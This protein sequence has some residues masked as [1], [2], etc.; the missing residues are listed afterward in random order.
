MPQGL[1]A[2][3]IANKILYGKSRKQILEMEGE[4]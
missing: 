4:F 3:M 2:S 1:N